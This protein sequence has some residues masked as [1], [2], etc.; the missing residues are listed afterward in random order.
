[1]STAA[2]TSGRARRAPRRVRLDA[3]T[4]VAAGLEL[5]A[6][7]GVSTIS[8]R[9]LGARL[10]A[11]PTAIYRHFR[12]KESL[13]EALLDALITRTLERVTAPVGEWR[14]RLRQLAD[15][16]FELFAQH[17]AIGVEATVLTTHGTGELGA[18]EFMLDTFARAGLDRD[19]QVRHY[20]LFASHVLAGSAGVARARSER[21]ALGETSTRWFDGPIAADPERFPRVASLLPELMQL[22]DHVLYELGVETILQSAERAAVQSAERAAVQSAERAASYDSAD[23]ERPPTLEK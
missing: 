12:S 13:M 2:S 15:A 5:A 9:D 23:V 17:P 4:I 18:V 14:D 8:V 20:A 22:E 1:M 7:P 21:A 10:G 11:D 6:T 3:E 19:E 16:T